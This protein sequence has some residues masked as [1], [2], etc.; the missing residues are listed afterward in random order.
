MACDKQNGVK[1][2][3]VTFEDC[4]T[5]QRFGPLSHRLAD[6]AEIPTV[7][8]CARVNTALT[9]G[10]VQVA[11]D[12][13]SMTLTIIKD[14]TIPTAWYQGCASLDIQVE[15][16]DGT[17]WTLTGGSV[18]EPDESDGHSVTMTVIAEEIF[19]TLP[20]AAIAA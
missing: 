15:K 16:L 17:I 9:G 4:N 10:Y 20:G 6:G 14:R 8:T 2:I 1:N 18:T 13:A 11:E 19:E 7:K 5:G 3:L 12:N